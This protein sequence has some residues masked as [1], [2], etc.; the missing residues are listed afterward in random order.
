MSPTRA[1]KLTQ[2]VKALLKA[3]S[4]SPTPAPASAQSGPAWQAL[5]ASAERHKLSHDTWLTLSVS[6]AGIL[7]GG[8]QLALGGVLTAALWTAG[9]GL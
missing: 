7:K 8:G 1:P 9:H 6:W 4:A 3:S 5:K 2:S